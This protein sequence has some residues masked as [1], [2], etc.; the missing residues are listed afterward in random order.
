VHST[1]VSTVVALI[2]LGILA[3]EA[4]AQKNNTVCAYIFFKNIRLDFQLITNLSM[5]A[6]TKAQIYEKGQRL[7]VSVAM[8]IINRN[9]I[10]TI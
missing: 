4:V 8:N 5:I 10:E 7:S 2:A 6:Q 1:E 9:G 3:N